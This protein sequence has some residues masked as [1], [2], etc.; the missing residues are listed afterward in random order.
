MNRKQI[1]AKILDLSKKLL[2]EEKTLSKEVKTAYGKMS[3]DYTKTSD[4]FMAGIRKEVD[5]ATAKAVYSKVQDVYD[6]LE[7]IST[8]LNRAGYKDF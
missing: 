7:G 8:V 4:T 5:E 2:A 6:A 3:V 1:A